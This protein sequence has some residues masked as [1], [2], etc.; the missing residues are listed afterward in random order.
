MRM[1]AAAGIAGLLIIGATLGAGRAEANSRPAAAGLDL[2]EGLQ[3]AAA[4]CDLKMSVADNP[5]TDGPLDV[6]VYQTY[7]MVGSGYAPNATVLIDRNDA[8]SSPL[9]PGSYLSPKT[10]A[11][12]SFE[13]TGVFPGDDPFPW[14][15]TWVFTAQ[16]AASGGCG[17]EVTV[18][19]IPA[20]PFTDTYNRRAF[21]MDIIWLWQSAITAGCAET[22]FCPTSVVTREQMASFLVRA[23]HLPATTADFFGDDESSIHEANINRLAAAGIT[24]GCAPGRFCPTATVTREQMASFLVRAFDLPSA[25]ID[26]FT[27]DETSIHEGDINRLALSGITG[28]CDANRY[29]PRAFVTREQM[30]AFLHRALT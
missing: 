13:A 27:D 18:G 9:P 7:T 1:R 26:Y 29:C 8:I 25:A 16:D 12:G 11:S 14:P 15:E 2:R 4:T 5:L 3:V 17:D 22:L 23:L 28:G 10:D 24:G 20:T 6:R 21:R 30:A 19:L